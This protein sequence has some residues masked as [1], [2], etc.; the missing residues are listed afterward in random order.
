MSRHIALPLMSAIALL[1]ATSAY[2]KA[3]PLKSD[4]A[5][6]AISEKVTSAP[7]R[8]QASI[9]ISAPVTEIYSY[10]SDSNKWVGWFPPYQS[11]ELSADGARRTFTFADGT[12]TLTEELV[13]RNQP[14]AFGWSFAPNNPLGVTD[15]LGLLTLEAKGEQ[16]TVTLTTFYNHPDPSLVSPQFEGGG[17]LI[18]NKISERF[19]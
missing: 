9:D 13:I 8:Y 10:V 18:L 17:Q 16:V 2:A 5:R 12:T 6:Q 19:K 1:S 3:H 4:Q 15:H 7:Q 11:V 14:H